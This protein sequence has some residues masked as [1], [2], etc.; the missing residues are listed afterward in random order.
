MLD[1][2]CKVRETLGKRMPPGLLV[3]I[4]GQKLVLC[5]RILSLAVKMFWK[6]ICWF[7]ENWIWGDLRN[8]WSW[9]QKLRVQRNILDWWSKF[10]LLTNLMLIQ[11][12][13][14]ITSAFIYF[15]PLYSYRHFD[16]SVFL[17]CHVGILLASSGSL[18]PYLRQ[19]LLLITLLFPI[20]NIVLE[21]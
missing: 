17:R 12:P 9:I 15:I 20:L 3:W 4:N 18:A 14:Y 19:G 16:H 2:A 10:F 8:A 1:S 21:A 11:R 13:A 6:V 5:T 7:L